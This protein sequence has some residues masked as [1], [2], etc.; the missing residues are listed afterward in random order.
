MSNQSKNAAGAQGLVMENLI[1]RLLA[2]SI[3]G[4]PVILFACGLAAIVLGT[5][6][7]LTVGV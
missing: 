5:V 6:V 1:G 7:A 3:A 2:S 4:I